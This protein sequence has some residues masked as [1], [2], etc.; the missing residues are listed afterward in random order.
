M[1]ILLIAAVGAFARL[2][3]DLAVSLSSAGFLGLAL[4][5][6]GQGLIRDLLEGTRALVEDRYALGDV[7]EVR[8]GGHETRGTVE[9]LGAASLGL[10]LESGGAWHAGHAAIESVMNESQLPVTTSIEVPAVNWARAD[11]A[12]AAEHLAGS[13]N[14]VGLTGVVFLGD[15]TDGVLPDENGVVSVPIRANRPLSDA[16]GHLVRD[17]VFG[18]RQE[19]DGSAVRLP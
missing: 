3:V 11:H 14:G 12:Q 5:L 8:I 18:G 17:R 9:V 13:S 1:L 2:G 19:P 6:S 4:A 7:V 16:E 10:R 15:L